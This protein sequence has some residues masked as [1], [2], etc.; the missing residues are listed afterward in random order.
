MLHIMSINDWPYTWQGLL[1]ELRGSSCTYAKTITVS[2]KAPYGYG[3]RLGDAILGQTTISTLCLE[4]SNLFHVSD[5]VVGLASLFMF[6]S[7]SASLSIVRLKMSQKC[8]NVQLIEPMLCAICDNPNI[9][10]LSLRR[11]MFA[12]SASWVHFLKNANSLQYLSLHLYN[13]EG[14]L[15]DLRGHAKLHTLSLS[16]D[17]DSKVRCNSLGQML[18][19]LTTL[20]HLKLTYVFFTEETMEHMLQGLSSFND[21]SICLSLKACSFD[22]SAM[23]KLVAF[24][25]KVVRGQVATSPICTLSLD[26][27][28]GKDTHIEAVAAMCTGVSALH[29]LSVD[30]GSR[31]DRMGGFL[32]LLVQNSPTQLRKLDL[33][34]RVD[35]VAVHLLSCFFR[36]EVNLEVLYVSQSSDVLQDKLARSLRYN[37]SIHC[38][39]F[40]WRDESELAELYSKRNQVLPSLLGKVAS[41]MADLSLFPFLFTVSQA[42]RSMAPNNMLIGLLTS[43]HSISPKAESK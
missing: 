4:L 7:T 11:D 2:T 15:K 29:Y 18:Q 1:T 19:G 12:P 5:T 32:D 6:L 33:Y 36:S 28:Q 13:C 14:F 34:G 38:A 40:N 23:E 8:D 22:K 25:P 30:F 27:H 41:R 17:K 16:F 24:M 3:A 43:R 37:G 39:T 9:F 10:D 21:A 42:A 20:R 35:E 26:V 31:N